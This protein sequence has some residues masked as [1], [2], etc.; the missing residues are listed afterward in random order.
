MPYVPSNVPLDYSDAYIAAELQRIAQAVNVLEGI[1]QIGF[2]PANGPFPNQV[3]T[4]SPLLLIN[5]DTRGPSELISDGPVNTDPRIHPANEIE[6]LIEGVYLI[7]YVFSFTHDL[8]TDLDFEVFKNGLV[9]GIRSGIDASQQ[10][11]RS[12]TN[13]SGLIVVGENDLYD[14]R[15]SSITAPENLQIG[16]GALS[17]FKLRDLRTRFS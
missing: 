11:T 12:T 15:V 17:L 2:D 9:T 7:S 4:G 16:S 3:V 13:A 1:G 5:F 10:T 8:G 6:V 14:I